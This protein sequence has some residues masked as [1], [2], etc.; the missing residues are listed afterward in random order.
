MAL[1]WN[2]NGGNAESPFYDMRQERI[3]LS[4]EEK[5]LLNTVQESGR[6][7]SSLPLGYVVG[8]L[9][10]EKLANDLNDSEPKVSF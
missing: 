1:L 8:E 3:R 7:D 6:F 5:A 2:W 4:T 10:R 9:C